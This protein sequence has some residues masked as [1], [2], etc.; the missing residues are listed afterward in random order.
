MKK[1]FA[2]VAFLLGSAPAGFAA[3]P[4][5]IVSFQGV[6]FI[7]AVNSTCSALNYA[8]GDYYTTVYRYRADPNATPAY[9][10]LTL[11]TQRS[12]FHILANNATG[13]LNGA[14]ATTNAFLDSRGGLTT[15]LTGST[16]FSIAS[17]GGKPTASAINLRLVG[18]IDNFFNNPGCTVTIHTNMVARPN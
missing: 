5:G 7:E 10:T 3:A 2:A 13:S 12:A 18:T 14:T 6:T 1:M 15:G 11:Y 8:V 16:S 17:A 9:D 4:P